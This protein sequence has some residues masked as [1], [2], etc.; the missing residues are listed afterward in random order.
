MRVSS[1]ST[2]PGPTLALTFFILPMTELWSMRRGSKP[3]TLSPHLATKTLWAGLFTSARYG[4]VPIPK[5]TLERICHMCS[6]VALTPIIGPRSRTQVHW[7]HPWW[8]SWWWLWR[9][10]TG[11]FWLRWPWWPRWSWRARWSQCWWTA[12][13][14]CQRLFPFP[15]AI[16]NHPAASFALLTLWPLSKLPYTIGWQDLK[17]LFRQ[18]GQC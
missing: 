16:H 9:R 2:F 15:T 10:F 13:L 17:D 3:S 1:P 7:H 12:D 8:W 4:P 11:W 18:A 5:A 6:S 14:R